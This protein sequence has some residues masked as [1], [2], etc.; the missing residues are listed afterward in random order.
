MIGSKLIR[1]IS[2]RIGLDRDWY[3]ILLAVIIGLVMGTAALVFIMPITWLENYFEHLD[4]DRLEWTSWL[5]LVLTSVTLFLGGEPLSPSH[6][7]NM[8]RRFQTR[9][10]GGVA[11][12]QSAQLAHPWGLVY[13]ENW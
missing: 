12:L 10:V 2:T 7:R 8:R 6:Q 13:K 11:Q 4:E 3:L 5:V 9:R 1:S